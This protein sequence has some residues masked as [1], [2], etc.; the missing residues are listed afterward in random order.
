ML[1]EHFL[2]SL[3][4]PNRSDIVRVRNWFRNA[5]DFVP[6]TTDGSAFDTE[7]LEA[8]QPDRHSG[9]RITKEPCP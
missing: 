9:L 1:P 3:F 6:T 8:A 4:R 5:T 7:T 2:Y